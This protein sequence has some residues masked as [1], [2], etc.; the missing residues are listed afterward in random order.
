MIIAQYF[1]VRDHEVEHKVW[2]HVHDVMD[3]NC[4]WRSDFRLIE[5][6]LSREF[7]SYFHVF[8][9]IE[10]VLVRSIYPQ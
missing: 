7:I 9:H 1:E 2:K 5:E 3:R 10:G 4:V 8:G 6:H